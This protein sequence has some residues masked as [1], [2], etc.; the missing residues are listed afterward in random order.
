MVKA[1][2]DSPSWSLWPRQST[3]SAHFLVQEARN[4][5]SRPGHQGLRGSCG[6]W[7]MLTRKSKSSRSRGRSG[8]GINPWSQKM[9]GLGMLVL[10][11]WSWIPKSQWQLESIVIVLWLLWFIFAECLL[12]LVIPSYRHIQTHSFVRHTFAT[13][14]PMCGITIG[15]L[16]RD[17]KTDHALWVLMVN[18]FPRR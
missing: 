14:H 5:L 18:N 1:S 10:L 3:E 9:H 13:F 7:P 8:L 4:W 12:M 17:T 16:S 11:G 15:K 6:R 2:R